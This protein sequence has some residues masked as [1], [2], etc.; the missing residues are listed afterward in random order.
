MTD[1]LSTRRGCF[2]Y[3]KFG[4]MGALSAKVKREATLKFLMPNISV[5][6]IFLIFKG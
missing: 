5:D 6:Y 2:Y 4:F 3:P 1:S